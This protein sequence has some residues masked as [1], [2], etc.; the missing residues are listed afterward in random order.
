MLSIEKRKFGICVVVLLLTFLVCVTAGAKSSDSRTAPEITV[1]QWMTDDPPD[2]KNLQGR[3]YVVD[4]WATWCHSCVEG[5]EELNKIN[6][7]YSQR[8]LVFLSLCQDK[9]P[10]TITQMIDE[11]NINFHVAID[12]GTA[13]WYE[14]KYYPTV[15][16][17]NHEGR[18]VW[19]GKPWDSKFVKSIEKAIAAAPAQNLPTPGYAKNAK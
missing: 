17:V 8:G 16:V 18:I 1:R 12:Y 2:V 7:K 6:D 19:Q 10:D 14:V 13:D 4:F 5:M 11:K 3:V 15:A 9:S